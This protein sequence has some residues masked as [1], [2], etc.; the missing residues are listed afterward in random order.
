MLPVILNDPAAL[1]EILGDLDLPDV[2]LCAL[3]G[4]PNDSRALDYTMHACAPTSDRRCDEPDKALVDM[5]V[6]STVEDP[7]EAAGPVAICCTLSPSLDLFQVLREAVEDD[8]LGGFSGI[9]VQIQFT[10]RAAG[11]PITEAEYAAK[12]VIYSLD[13]PVGEVA[14][15]NP[16]LD[17]L[18]WEMD[19]EVE[20]PLPIGRCPDVAPTTVSPGQ[21]MV[22]LPKENELAR[23]D[24]VVAT[25]D[26]GTRAFTENLRYSWYATAGRWRGDQSGGPRDIAG[27]EPQLDTI[28]VAPED[29]DAPLDASVW[30]VQ[31][32]ERGGLAWYESCIRVDPGLTP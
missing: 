12:R 31:R 19:D 21:E 8:P 2:E 7:E 29:L 17:Q 11:A 30:V 3:V 5:V 26:G 10:V 16:S 15:K 22:L 1:A 4:D 6:I 18:V 24:Y 20:Q 14:N 27:N 28:W 32:D 25:F 9:P 23:E 13:Y